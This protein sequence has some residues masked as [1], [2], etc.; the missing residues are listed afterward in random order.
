MPVGSLSAMS[1]YKLVEGGASSTLTFKGTKVSC[2][3]PPFVCSHSAQ[4]RNDHVRNVLVLS[5][6]ACRRES[7]VRESWN[8]VGRCRGWSGWPWI[9]S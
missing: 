6:T 8:L 2:T 9:S 1:L 3:R 4:L 5:L 7:Q